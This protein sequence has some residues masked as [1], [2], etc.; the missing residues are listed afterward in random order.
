MEHLVRSDNSWWSLINLP[1]LQVNDE[2]QMHGVKVGTVREID[3]HPKN[4]NT[5]QVKFSVDDNDL[6]IPKETQLWLI[7][8]D[9]LG[10]KVLDLRIPPDSMLYYPDSIYQDGDLFD[11]NYVSIALSM[12]KELEKSFDPL[13]NRTED[14]ITRVE[15]IIFKV[16][17]YWDN[18]GAYAFDASMYDVRDAIDRYNEHD[19]ESDRFGEAWNLSS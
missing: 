2:V 14:L 8:S 5:V 7:S 18:S 9:I 17:S 19:R 3:L 15:D 16:S 11:P 10:T 12:D 13:K 4:A 1:G 6:V